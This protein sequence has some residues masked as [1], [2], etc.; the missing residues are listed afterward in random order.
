MSGRIVSIGSATPDHRYNQVDLL[1]YMEKA[2][3]ADPLLQRQLQ[4]LYTR[5]GISHRYSVLPDFDPTL[6]PLLFDAEYEANLSDRLAIFQKEAVNLAEKAC[7]SVLEPHLPP[8]EITHLITVSCT[9][10]F[11]PGLEF[12][13]IKRLGLKAGVH[14]HPIN[15]VGCYAA[16]PALDLARTICEADP[17][18]RVLLVSVELCT[19]HF[20][21]EASKDNVLAN[22]LFADGAAAC[23]VVG[24]QVPLHAQLRIGKRFAEVYPDGETEMTWIPAESGFLMRLSS[25]VPRII[26]AEIEQFVHK[27][28]AHNQ[29]KAS[30]V[31]WAF[32]PGGQQILDRSASALHLEKE[33]L[34]PSYQILNR[35]GNM[36][37]ATV[38]FVVES[39]LNNSL[40]RERP[41]FCCA[42][43]P[44]LTFE[45]IPLYHV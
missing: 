40:D 23:L 27:S 28:L 38:L 3:R 11:A 31:T 24:E 39:L 37:S 10:L 44:G 6:D 35:Y 20:Q 45:S 12:E 13:L 25:Y 41:L 2:H 18:A 8:S 1:P 15:F 26:E 17:G 5:G 16:I 30:E 34:D 32:H 7:R 4:L 21:K 33:E 19:L 36:S 42:F 29:L 22:A 43:G 9:G 14:R